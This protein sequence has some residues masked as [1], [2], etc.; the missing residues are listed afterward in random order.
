[1]SKIKKDGLDQ[2]GAEPFEQ[3]Q[4]ETAGVERVNES[5]AVVE[6]SNMKV[7][8]RCRRPL[9]VCNAL[10]VIYVY[11]IVDDKYFGQTDRQTD[12][13][14][15]S[16]VILCLSSAK[17]CTGQTMTQRLLCFTKHDAV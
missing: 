5:G 15:Y 1:M 14:I 13:H 7:L 9:A 4:F 3:Q 2:Y 17:H 10:P 6:Y 11:R 16:Q 12:R 8:R